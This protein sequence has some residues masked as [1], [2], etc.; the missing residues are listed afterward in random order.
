MISSFEIKTNKIIPCYQRE[1][2]GSGVGKK[3]VPIINQD[4]GCEK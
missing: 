4:R 3:I 1:R 2:E